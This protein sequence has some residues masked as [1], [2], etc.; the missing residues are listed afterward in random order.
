MRLAATTRDAGC[1]RRNPRQTS[2]L[3]DLPAHV[4]VTRA[5]HALT[6][7]VLAVFGQLKR[8]GQLNLVLILPDGTRSY[9]PAAWTDFESP[10]TPPGQGQP[11][12]VA[13]LPD[14]LRTR[15]RVDVLLRRIGSTPSDTTASTQENQHACKSNGTM[16]RGTAPDSAPVSST[17]PRAAEPPRSLFGGSDAKDGPQSSRPDTAFNS[18]ANA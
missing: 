4:R 15:Q 5:Q 2:P 18:H 1:C 9:I 14:L 8:K 13:L 7:K 3:R 17:Q 16:V 12:L 11:S 10:G 6:G